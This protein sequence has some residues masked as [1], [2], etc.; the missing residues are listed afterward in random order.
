MSNC[1]IY[2]WKPFCENYPKTFAIKPNII[3][4]KCVFIYNF[5]QS[6]IVIRVM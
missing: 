4:Q 1:K 2:L 6:S 3:N 5:I